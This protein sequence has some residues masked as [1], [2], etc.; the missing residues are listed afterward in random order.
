[1]TEE[2][3]PVVTSSTNINS[4]HSHLLNQIFEFCNLYNDLIT[5]SAC[6]QWTQEEVFASPIWR[7]NPI[8][9]CLVP[10]CFGCG[11]TKLNSRR[12]W[13]I[14]SL[15]NLRSVRL[16][17]RLSHFL[18]SL[19][20]LGISGK[21]EALHFRLDNFDHSKRFSYPAKDFPSLPKLS[22]LVIYNWPIQVKISPFLHV[23][24]PRLKTLKFMESCPSDIF[25]TLHEEYL[26]IT[27]LV[28]E[29]TQAHSDDRTKI[30]RIVMKPTPSITHFTL[31]GSVL[32]PNGF[33]AFV[34]MKRLEL[35]DW[36][37]DSAS[38]KIFQT[39]PQT[40]LELEIN[41]SDKILSGLISS[42]GNNT[43]NLQSLV[44]RV[45]CT[46][47]TRR[48]L[49]INAMT[50]LTKNCSNLMNFQLIGCLY[51]SVEA[52]SRLIELKLLKKLALPLTEEILLVLPTFLSQTEYLEEIILQSIES[53]ASKW[54]SI[55]EQ[56]L[57]ISEL[58]PAVRITLQEDNGSF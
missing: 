55:E 41:V 16:H 58:N 9:I 54:E 51:L 57:S 8:D 48:E 26:K 18:K 1:M 25:T 44:V 7:N 53:D 23:L 39:I 5:F 49:E 10:T 56:L 13:K 37:E 27:N 22:S 42:I 21:V 24:G 19:Q 14:C 29:V 35:L 34:S 20:K 15:A 38:M 3:S 4:L 31:R 47:K 30:E 52:F 17:L 6:S 12:A 32:P 45:N 28:I 50:S 40:L 36:Y 2:R 46:E 43:P 11:R 33:N